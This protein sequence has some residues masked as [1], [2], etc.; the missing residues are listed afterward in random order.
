METT[1]IIGTGNFLRPESVLREAG[2]RQGMKVAHFGSGPGFFAVPAA[3]FVGSDGRV[4]AIDIRQ[5]AVEEISHRARQKGLKNLDVFRA[6]LTKD[7]ASNLPDSWADLIILTNILHQSDP[8]LVM[9]EAARVVR[10]SSGRVVAVEWDVVASPLGPAVEDRI[11]PD[12]VIAA[13]RL[14]HLVVLRNW[15][16]S[17]YHYAF[18]FAKVSYED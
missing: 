17:L 9:A 15:K 7:G 16:P 11:A 8:Q 2:I 4:V 10:P 13:G 3:Q 6:D 12:V 18:I 1:N 5:Q 14:N